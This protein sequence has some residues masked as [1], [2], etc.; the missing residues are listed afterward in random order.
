MID[1][2][3]GS[4]FKNMPDLVKKEICGIFAT[5]KPYKRTKEKIYKY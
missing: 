2:Q 3:K 5:K 1:V 4:G